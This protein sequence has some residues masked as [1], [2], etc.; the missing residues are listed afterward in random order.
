MNPGVVSSLVGTSLLA[1]AL[2]STLVS[3]PVPVPV[4]SAPPLLMY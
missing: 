3:I 4:A 1:S 2:V